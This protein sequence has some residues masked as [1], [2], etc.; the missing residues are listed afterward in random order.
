MTLKGCSMVIDAEDP[1][2]LDVHATLKWDEKL[3]ISGSGACLHW[4]P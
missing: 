3:D 2:L 4:A 1:P